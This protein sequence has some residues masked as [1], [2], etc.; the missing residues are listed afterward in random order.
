MRVIREYTR[1]AGVRNLERQLSKLMRKGLVR[2]TRK[3]AEKVAITA[4]TLEDFCGCAEV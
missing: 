3:E 2:I 4:E 1:E